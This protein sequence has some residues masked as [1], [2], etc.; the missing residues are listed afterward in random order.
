MKKLPLI[1][2]LLPMPC[3]LLFA[4]VSF[5]D[6]V[7]GFFGSDQELV[8]GL[9]FSNQYSLV[10]GHPYFLDEQFR[11]GSLVVN[12]E[13]YQGQQIRYN[14][15]S[16]RLELE[17]RTG[18]GHLNQIITVP[19]QIPSFTLGNRYFVRLRPGEEP[20]AYYQVISAGSVT[21]YIGWK[22]VKKLS[23]SDSSR[24]YMFSDPQSTFWL[25]RDQQYSS[26]HNRKSFVALF[27]EHLQKEISRLLKQRKFFFRQSGVPE[28][29]AMIKA[30]MQVYIRGEG[31]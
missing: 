31:Q 25:E 27:P 1:I 30:A 10:D 23:R 5:P 14:L 12:D 9:Q 21:C 13:V 3:G 16:Q 7:E 4:Q 6:L 26:F 22:K 29:E 28:T 24:E 8:N 2:F 18:E 20:R 15:F 11:T 19:G 17:Y